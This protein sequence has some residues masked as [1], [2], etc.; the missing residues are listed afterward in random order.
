MNHL[1]PRPISH[2]V[3]KKTFKLK[4]LEI[5]NTFYT[6]DGYKNHIVGFCK[7][8]DTTIVIYKFWLKYKGYWGYECKEF[9][10]ILFS[11]STLYDLSKEDT[12]SLFQL[13]GIE[14]IY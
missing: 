10:F 1:K 13:N 12:Q 7:D 4:K 11:L 6:F 9:K 2:R 3:S 5:G 8:G 14:P